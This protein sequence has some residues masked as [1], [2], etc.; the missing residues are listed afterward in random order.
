MF[1]QRE[2]RELEKR[3]KEQNRLPPGQSATIKFPVLHYGPAGSSASSGWWARSGS[4]RGR[5]STNC[6][7][8]R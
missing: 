3:M 1:D 8:R 6:R 4:G 5:S 7:A 2:R